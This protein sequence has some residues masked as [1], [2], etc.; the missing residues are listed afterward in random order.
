MRL[1]FYGVRGSI[2]TPDEE[3]GGYG[4]NTSC[5]FLETKAGTRVVLDAG[6]GLRWLATDL[7]AKHQGQPIHL[8]VLLSHFY[9]DH[10][11]GIPFAPVMYIPGNQVDI[12]GFGGPTLSLR[13]NLL[14]QMQQDYCP[15]PNFFLHDDVGATVKM[16]E[17]DET[18]FHLEEVRVRAR[19]L[20]SGER[21][22]VGGYRVECEGTVVAYLTDVEYPSG[23]AGCPEAVELAHHADLLIHDGQYL[24]SERETSRGW[25]H[26]T[27]E[28]AVELARLAQAKRLLI[29]HHDPSRTDE[30]LDD[31]AALLAGL[32]FP[33]AP[34]REGELI[35]LP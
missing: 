33:A 21:K 10:I 29:F 13:D 24:A 7:L 5:V 15:V 25:G 2:T 12:Y 3:C 22:K 26:S 23:P 27:V 6:M 30:E 8:N 9:W 32:D 18:E 35:E 14:S 11:Q 17:I 34:A 4:G 1:E 20:P 28:E 16:H 31:I 19:L